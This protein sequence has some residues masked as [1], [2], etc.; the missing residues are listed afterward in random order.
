MLW[1]L[2]TVSCCAEAGVVRSWL[3]CLWCACGVHVVCIWCAW[4]VDWGSP[5]RSWFLCYYAMVVLTSDSDVDN[6]VAYLDLSVLSST[7]DYIASIPIL[8]QSHVSVPIIL[9]KVLQAPGCRNWLTDWGCLYFSIKNS[10]LALLEAVFARI[11]IRFETWVFYDHIFCFASSKKC[12]SSK[13]KKTVSLDLILPH[14]IYIHI[15]SLYTCLNIYLTRFS[16]SWFFGHSKCLVPSPG[17]TSSTPYTVC[18]CVCVYLCVHVY[19]HV[20][21]SVH[22]H[23][24][25]N[26]PPP[27]SKIERQKTTL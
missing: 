17:L 25:P 26:T 13:R 27:A 22:T 3:T 8:L 2:V 20:H 15:C 4:I 5:L 23:V 9:H 1:C 7:Q 12:S 11:Y 18:V 10:L 21:P 6:T 14:S 24:H 16:L 19:T